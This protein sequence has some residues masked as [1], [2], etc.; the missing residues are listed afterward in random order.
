MHWRLYRSGYHLHARSSWRR[1]HPERRQQQRGISPFD[2]HLLL[3]RRI[4]RSEEDRMDPSDWEALEHIKEQ[5]QQTAQEAAVRRA[6]ATRV[7]QI[8]S[9]T[10]FD[11]GDFEQGAFQQTSLRELKQAQEYESGLLAART[12]EIGQEAE[13][14]LVRVLAG[15]DAQAQ[16]FQHGQI[17]ALRDEL[18]PPGSS[19]EECL[20]ANVIAKARFEAL[21]WSVQISEL[22]RTVQPLSQYESKSKIHN[23]HRAQ[24]QVQV[25]AAAKAQD[26]AQA[27]VEERVRTAEKRH[28]RALREL[29]NLRRLDGPLTQVVD[30]V[31]LPIE[32]AGEEDA[33]E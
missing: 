10:A 17:A 30:S 25:Q 21:L 18:A 8:T 9:K 27:Q 23:D 19:P 14:A 28:L 15:N 2:L 12:Q 7:H 4:V 13:A 24:A 31:P 1:A 32:L 16:A 11:Q 3:A 22:L 26:K 33:E 20:L 29:A 5:M 6:Q